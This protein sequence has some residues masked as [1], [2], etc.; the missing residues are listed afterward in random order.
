MSSKTEIV[1]PRR[2]Y[3]CGP[4]SGMKEGN[5]PEFAK[6]QEEFAALDVETVN[7]TAIGLTLDTPWNDAMKVCIVEMLECDGVAMLPNWIASSRG[8]R[9]E[10]HVAIA[11]GIEVAYAMDWVAHCKGKPVSRASRLVQ[12]RAQ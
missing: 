2:L 6:W 1:K 11:V 8:C 12:R 4:V 7:P 10:V 9:L 3:L 5:A